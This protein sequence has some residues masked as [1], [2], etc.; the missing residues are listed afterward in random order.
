MTKVIDQHGN[1]YPSQEAYFAAM[2]AK[3]P[4]GPGIVQIAKDLGRVKR[5]KSRRVTAPTAAKTIRGRW[6]RAHRLGEPAPW[7][8]RWFAEAEWRVRKGLRAFGPGQPDRNA[9]SRSEF[10][11]LRSTLADDVEALAA[12]DRLEAAFA[13]DG[14]LAEVVDTYGRRW[15]KDGTYYAALEALGFGSDAPV[16]GRCVHGVDLDAEFCPEGCRV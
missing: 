16:L 9:A 10:P 15:S 12:L 1:A 11:Q 13:S 3:H 4:L 6:L 2:T 7:H 5:P 8:K 14:V